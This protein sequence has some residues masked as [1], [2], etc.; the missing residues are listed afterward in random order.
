MKMKEEARLGFAI[1]FVQQT[2]ISAYED[3]CPL[4]PVRTARQSLK[5]TPELESSAEQSEGSLIIVEQVG[6]HQVGNSTRES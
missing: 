3:N 6:I 2:L 4:K 5:W 1:L